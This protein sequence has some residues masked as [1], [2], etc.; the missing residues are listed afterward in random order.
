[1]PAL[2]CVPGVANHNRLGATAP[3]LTQATKP[4]AVELIEFFQRSNEPDTAKASS[5]E[6]EQSPFP[7]SFLAIPAPAGKQEN[8]KYFQAPDLWRYSWVTGS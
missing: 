2:S 4:P 8:A 7:V 1:M 6:T 3:V 5:F